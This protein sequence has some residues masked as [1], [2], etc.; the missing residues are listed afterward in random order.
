MQ[1]KQTQGVENCGGKK[2]DAHVAGGTGDFKNND[3]GV[4]D[5]C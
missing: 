1:L 5:P 2:G 4:N 3:P